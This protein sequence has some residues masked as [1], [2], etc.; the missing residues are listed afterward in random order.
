[1]VKIKKCRYIG[2]IGKISRENFLRVDLKEKQK[3]RTTLS[4]TLWAGCTQ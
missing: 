2:K 1:M 4:G 3:D